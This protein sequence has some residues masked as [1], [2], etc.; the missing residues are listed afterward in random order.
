MPFYAGKKKRSSIG[1]NASY[2]PSYFACGAVVYPFPL[3]S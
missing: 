2:Q 1:D 3:P